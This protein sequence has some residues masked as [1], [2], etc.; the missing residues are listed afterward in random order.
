MKKFTDW[1]KISISPK[2]P[3]HY[4]ILGKGGHPCLA[5]FGDLNWYDLDTRKNMDMTD[6]TSWR[7][8]DETLSED[9]F[10]D[11]ER[12]FRENRDL[13]H[14]RSMFRH[15]MSEDDSHPKMC[16]CY[17]FIIALVLK[18]QF[19]SAETFAFKMQMT[20]WTDEIKTYSN[21]YY[22]NEVNILIKAIRIFFIY[23]KEDMRTLGEGVK[24]FFKRNDIPF[25]IIE[26]IF[27]FAP[28]VKS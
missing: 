8:C 26:M 3:G 9:K 1:F 4:Q 24:P 16:A 13:S 27:Y 18:V 14:V 5:K 11:F 21:P 17:Y 7:G 15:L 10:Y 22:H 2:Y 28:Y 25:D 19:S 12:D 6:I 20:E 23:Q